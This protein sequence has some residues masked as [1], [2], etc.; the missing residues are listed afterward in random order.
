MDNNNND[1]NN[2]DTNN[3]SRYFMDGNNLRAS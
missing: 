2:N 3:T 1:T